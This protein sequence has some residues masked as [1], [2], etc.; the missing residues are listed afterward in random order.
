MK[1]TASCGRSRRSS[2][3]RRPSRRRRSRRALVSVVHGAQ[4]SLA[5]RVHRVLLV[6]RPVVHAA[7]GRVVGAGAG[8]GRRQGHARDAGTRPR[9]R[10]PRVQRRAAPA[11]PDRRQPQ[12]GA[13]RG[14]ARGPHRPEPRA[15]AVLLAARAGTTLDRTPRLFRPAPAKHVTRPADLE[16]A[17]FWPIA[18]LAQL[19][20]SKQVSSVE[21]T[22]MYLDRLHRYN[23]TL[24]CV[25]TFTDDLAMQQARQAD[26][27]IA[28][29]R[30]RGPLHGIPWGCKDIIAV[31][32][33]P[34]QWG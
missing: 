33:Y 11:D 23:G 8:A 1:W 5:A 6:D 14:A 2:R 13:V 31:P 18:D 29:G 9:G 15:A 32:G 24:N 17:A 7:A 21:L 26:Q 27:D 19:L 3:R 12:P 28:A 34:T 10:G 30:Y 20:K 25:V 22:R 4:R 16:A